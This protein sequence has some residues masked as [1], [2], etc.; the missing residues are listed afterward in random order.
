MLSEQPAGL[1]Q[2]LDPALIA[3]ISLLAYR[4]DKGNDGFVRGLV[5]HRG[6]RGRFMCL[7]RP[8]TPLL[9]GNCRGDGERHGHEKGCGPNWRFHACHIR[10]GHQ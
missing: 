5:L 10:C 8:A 4:K 7:R 9:P 1:R 3:F 6:R 2:Q